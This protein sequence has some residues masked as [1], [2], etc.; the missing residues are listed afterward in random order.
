MFGLNILDLVII[1]FALLAVGRGIRLGFFRQ[2]F[3]L[4]GFFAGL[5]LGSIIAPFV[6]QAA[7]PNQ[8]IQGLMTLTLTFGLAI[9]LASLGEAFGKNIRIN[10]RSDRIAVAENMFGAAISVASAVILTWLMAS[11]LMRLPTANVA[12]N[13]NDS[14]IIAELDERLPPAPSI[15]SRIGQLLSP[16]GFPT[17]FTGIEPFSPSA[18]EPYEPD[19]LAA[20]EK[21][22]ISTV[23]IEGLG[24]GGAVFGSGFVISDEVIATNAHVVA[25]ISNP[26][27]A[28]Q[29][30]RYRAQTIHF[31]PDTD[32]ALL[33]VN[34]HAG[35]PLQLA[36]DSSSRGTTAAVLGYPNGGGFTANS[37]V[38]LSRH[39]AMGR[40]IYDTSISHRDVYEL[41]TVIKQGNSGGPV[42]LPDGT[43]IGMIF[44]KSAARE[45]RGYAITS[46]EIINALEE[47][48]S[49]RTAVSTGRCVS[50]V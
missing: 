19:V 43:V 3:S 41:Q 26:I 35:P 48:G 5:F 40:N 1:I 44:G 7:G 46:M 4:A 50:A 29:G 49:S 18:G 28:D 42:V 27:V 45:S 30:G 14:K 9:I 21:A 17:V 8:V 39:M 10:I 24:C 11:V 33:R 34:D 47:A 25:G 15:L 36:A 22:A 20:A 2:I 37:A 13:I 23:R 38:I 16:D 12:A 6:S 31:D 32:L